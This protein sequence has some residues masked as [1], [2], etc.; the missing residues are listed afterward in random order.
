MAEPVLRDPARRPGPQP[1]PAAAPAVID[2]S[3]ELPSHTISNR[4][5]SVSARPPRARTPSQEMLEEL[6]GRLEHLKNRVERHTSETGI[7]LKREFRRDADYV[8]IRAR[9]YHDRRPLQTL[10]M[11]AAAGFVLGVFVGL[12]R[13]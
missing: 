1:V 12:W 4:T 2:P 10:G 5:S 7:S 8:K 13:R 9:Y 11:V 6:R 3:H